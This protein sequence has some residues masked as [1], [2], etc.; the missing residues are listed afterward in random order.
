[1][2][3]SNKNLSWNTI[4]ERDWNQYLPD[5]FRSDDSRIVRVFPGSP[6]YSEVVSLRY[7]GLVRSGYLD[8][9]RHD[10][11]CMR[12]ARDSDSI[13]VALLIDHKVSASLTFNTPTVRFPRLAMELEKGIVL[14]HP[15]FHDPGTLEFVKLVAA[16]HVRP[17]RHGVNLFLLGCVLGVLFSKTHFWH[18][19][20]TVEPA[21]AFMRKFGFAYSESNTFVDA[22]LNNTKSC[23]GYCSLDSICTSPEVPRDLR[24]CVMEILKTNKGT[25]PSNAI[26]KRECFAVA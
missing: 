19:S 16:P 1:M 7:E 2:N 26:S 24:T 9:K 14:D 6:L 18:V 13:I 25:E 23:A 22:G 5:R 10:I 20:R 15:R 11:S 8:P 12:L 21:M 17:L 4:T 3:F